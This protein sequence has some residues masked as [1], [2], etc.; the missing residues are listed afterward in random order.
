VPV[1]ADPPA[2]EDAPTALE[3]CLRACAVHSDKLVG[4][5]DA[6][7]RALAEQLRHLLALWV[8]RR[9]APATTTSGRQQQGGTRTAA[10]GGIGNDLL[11]ALLAVGNKALDCGYE[12]ELDL[13]LLITDTVLAHRN[14]RAGWRLRGRLLEAVGRPVAAAEAYERYL[15]LTPDDGFGLR[16]RIAGITAAQERRA[17]LLAVLSRSVPGAAALSGLPPTD[18]WAEGLHLHALGHWADAQDRLVG[19]LLAMDR[20]EAS[21][22][23]FLEALGQYLDLATTGHVRT[24]PELDETVRLFAELRRNRIR[25]PIDDPL[26]GGVQWLSLGEFRNRAAGKSVCLVANSGSVAQSSL[27]SAIDAYDVVVR[28]SSYRLDPVHTGERT[29]IHV[30][31]HKHTFNW[32]KPVTTRLVLGAVPD[33]W[34]ASLRS[35]LVPGAQKYLGDES[36]RRPL[37]DLG[38]AGSDTAPEKPSSGLTMLWL[39]DFLDVS[40]TLDLIGF[41]FFESGA[42]RLDAAK[43]VPIG[44][45]RAHSSEK[46]WVM[47]RAQSISGNGMRISLR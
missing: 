47:E 24:T 20:V 43:K 11:D 1:D 38:G 32:D 6:R 12:D 18:T 30:S 45:V 28:F 37:R 8:A 15:D 29:D 14:S 5:L 10:D 31:V 42:Y 33:D 4:S 25:G 35:R 13:A 16:T 34:K 9:P 23:D 40:P 17:E 39:L 41:D 44:S 3:D 26:L 46:A 36:L 22:Q 7:R 19:A 27:G 2:A 21:E